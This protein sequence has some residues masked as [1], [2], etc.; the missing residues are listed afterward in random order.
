[1]IRAGS[2]TLGPPE[3]LTSEPLHPQKFPQDPANGGGGIFASP[4]PESQWAFLPGLCL[5]TQ[6][7][8]FLIAEYTGGNRWKMRQRTG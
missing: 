7:Q 8:Q 3:S 1:L 4:L 2:R 6:Q 5:Q